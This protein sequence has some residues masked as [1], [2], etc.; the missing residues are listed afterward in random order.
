MDSVRVTFLVD[1]KLYKAF[2]DKC[3]KEGRTMTW[4]FTRWMR[5]T[6]GQMSLDEALSAAEE[7]SKSRRRK[8]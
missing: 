2:K 6:S 1:R 8:S 7:R 4:Y 5:E 3:R